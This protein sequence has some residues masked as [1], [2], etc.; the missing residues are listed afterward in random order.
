MY[1]WWQCN[2]YKVFRRNKRIWVRVYIRCLPSTECPNK[3]NWPI[4]T[5]YGRSQVSILLNVAI[6]KHFLHYHRL[7]FF[8]SLFYITWN[9][10]IES[11][12]W[13]LSYRSLAGLGT[14]NWQLHIRL[15][16][17]PWTFDLETAVLLV[18][19]QHQQSKILILYLLFK[20]LGPRSVRFLVSIKYLS[21]LPR[22]TWL[23]VPCQLIPALLV[24]SLKFNST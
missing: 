5:Y 19:F 12:T 21:V 8:P 20:F 10:I 24:V 2:I 23:G 3:S 14:K 6:M 7:N 15:I 17:W 18:G 4:S 13:L 16:D 22:Q 1:V 11:I 9:S